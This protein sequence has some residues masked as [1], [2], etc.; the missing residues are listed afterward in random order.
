MPPS[1]AGRRCHV[2][3]R[4]RTRLGRPGARAMCSPASAGPRPQRDQ[5][6]RGPTSRSASCGGRTPSP[7]TMR[8]S[9]RCALRLHRHL[10]PG[11]GTGLDLV[12]DFL[13]GHAEIQEDAVRVVN[14]LV[15]NNIRSLP[16]DFL[17]YHQGTLPPYRSRP[18]PPASC[19]QG[20][21]HS[22]DEVFDPD[23]AEFY[24]PICLFRRE[25]WYWIITRTMPERVSH[26]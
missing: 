20:A 2:P 17:A 26:V 14:R 11:T 7:T 1:L 10:G 22:P 4:G 9:A 18:Q 13:P 6:R 8:P 12:I 15:E 25:F 21:S 5:S 24:G 23:H 3:A 19:S 16:E